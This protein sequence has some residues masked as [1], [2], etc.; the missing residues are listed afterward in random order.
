MPP[1]VISCAYTP[2]S[3]DEYAKKLFK[4][5]KTF[6]YSVLHQILQTF[7]GKALLHKH[8]DDH[9]MSQTIAKLREY[10]T[11]SELSRHEIMCL[12]MS[13]ITIRLD[14][15]WIGTAIKFLSVSKKEQLSLLD[16][17]VPLNNFL[18]LLALP[19]SYI[20][21]VGDL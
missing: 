15:S 7:K 21:Q 8:A 2:P 9:D 14:S 6:C 16:N 10:Y 12:Y 4:A 11:N 20:L 18:K 5:Q 13:I 3:G 1:K 19:S 17:L